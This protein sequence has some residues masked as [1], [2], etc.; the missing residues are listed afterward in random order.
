[1]Q[2]CLKFYVSLFSKISM[3]D[4]RLLQPANGGNALSVI[5]VFLEGICLA[6][7]MDL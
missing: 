5:Q 3:C 7:S 4:V 6:S 2:F 1:M